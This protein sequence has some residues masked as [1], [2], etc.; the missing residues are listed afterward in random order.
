[1][2]FS[3]FVVTFPYRARTIRCL[4]QAGMQTPREE[5]I[6]SVQLLASQICSRQSTDVN[7]RAF[8]LFS[9]CFF[10]RDIYVLQEGNAFLEI[11][12]QGPEVLLDKKESKKEKLVHKNR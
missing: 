4:A 10:L 3:H 1:M 7:A 12:N 6:V 5:E 9:L 11:K 8:F 2:N